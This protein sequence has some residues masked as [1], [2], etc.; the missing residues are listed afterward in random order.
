MNNKHI[1]PS[2]KSSKFYRVIYDKHRDIFYRIYKEENKQKK[3][4]EYLSGN[5]H[6]IVLNN[7]FEKLKEFPLNKDIYPYSALITK[8]GL[9]FALRAEKMKDMN[10]MRFLVM[11]PNIIN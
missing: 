8:E 3:H 2:V 6:L 4:S 9:I 5:Y 7:E 1:M 10:C 11:K